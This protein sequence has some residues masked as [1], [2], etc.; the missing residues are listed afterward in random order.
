MRG[1]LDLELLPLG[2]WQAFVI[3]NLQNEARHAFAEHLPEFAGGRAG[4]LDGVVKYRRDQDVNIIDPT[5]IRQ[6]VCDLERVIDVGF[7]PFAFA[8]LI[9]VLT[10]RVARRLQ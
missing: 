8:F 1:V 4:I 2:L 6:Q 9:G 5:D 3:G 7:A 10:S